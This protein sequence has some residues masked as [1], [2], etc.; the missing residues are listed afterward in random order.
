MFK[1]KRFVTAGVNLTVDF[2]LQIYLWN[3]VD[4]FDAEIKKDYLQVFDLSIVEKNR[5][6]IQKIVHTQ[7]VP[8]YR[9]E[10]IVELY[11]P[12]EAKIFII[13]DGD[14]STML[15]TEEY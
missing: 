11:N 14:H 9:R 7:E 6:K 8:E 10:Y 15:L 2:L 13:D 1:N 4:K 12:I 5:K 3:L